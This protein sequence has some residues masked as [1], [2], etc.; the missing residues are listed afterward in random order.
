MQSELDHIVRD[1]EQKFA[2]GNRSLKD[3]G[4][5]PEILAEQYRPTAEK[6]VRR[7]LILGKLIDQEKLELSDDE[8][9]QGFQEMADAY[10]QP[11]EFI[12]SYYEKNQDGL[13]LFKHTLLEKK[14]LK[15]I[16]DNS[17]ITEIEPSD[18]GEAEES[19]A[20]SDA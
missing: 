12:K 5:T 6:Q 15:L 17:D 18:K 14:V 13:T 16:I 4:L 10:G 8:T 7:H 2:G 19:S 9:D 3:V 1:A 11:M 20:E